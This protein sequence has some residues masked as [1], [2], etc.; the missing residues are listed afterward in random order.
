MTACHTKKHI[1]LFS[2]NRNIK[3]KTALSITEVLLQVQFIRNRR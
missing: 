1:S 2:K 3:Y